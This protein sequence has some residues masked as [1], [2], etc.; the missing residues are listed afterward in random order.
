VA[1][2]PDSPSARSSILLEALRHAGTFGVNNIKIDLVL[3]DA[4]ASSSSLYHHFKSRAGL[5]EA[6]RIEQGRLGLLEEDPT[7]LEL[8]DSITTN[9]DFCDYMA[10]RLRRI[11]TDPEA[12]RRR[13]TRLEAL[14][15]PGTD[16]PIDV[17]VGTL[18]DKTSAFVQS[19]IDRR[20]CNP[21]LDA[22]AYAVVFMSLSLGQIATRNLMDDE[23]WLITATEAAIAPLRC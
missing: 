14:S 8:L 4:Y 9:D 12:T 21:H 19:A 13:E 2:T 22:R 1:T 5:L 17:L 7:L 16:R 6:V 23:Q 20:L 18:I 3:K 15:Q 11:V 10:N